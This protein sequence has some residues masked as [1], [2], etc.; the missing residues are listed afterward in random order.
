M[1]RNELTDMILDTKR[2]LKFYEDI[3]P[4]CTTCKELG[5]QN[6]CLVHDAIVPDEYLATG[7]DGWTY[8]EIP[9]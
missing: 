3:K 1:T 9:F 6:K 7:C 4:D 2:A 8:D 5:A